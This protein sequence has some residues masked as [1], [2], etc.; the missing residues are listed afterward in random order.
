MK[1][2]DFL[3]KHKGERCFVICNG[4]SLNKHNL[5]LLKN[6][7]TIG[8]NRIYL[9]E[10]FS[11]TYYTIEDSR[12]VQQFHEEINNWTKPQIKFIP[13]DYRTVITGDDVVYIKFRKYKR[14]QLGNYVFKFVEKP[15][16]IFYWGGS[17]TFLS[18]QLAH[19]MGCNPI[20]I[21]GADHYWGEKSKRRGVE[22]STEDDKWHFH[23]DYYGKGKEWNLPVVDR[24]TR[25][26]ECARKAANM[27]GF[28]IYNATIGGYLEV[29]D[30]VDY[31][32]LFRRRNSRHD[33]SWNQSVC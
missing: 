16:P 26:Y 22:I 31:D 30:R 1:I 10:S 23:P 3:D 15:K 5:N 14:G 27:Y 6:E 18:L 13:F 24:I 8:A 29:F 7:I 32:A 4:P 21:I 12:D 28:R 20:Y 2:E 17:V 9:H 11:P 25:S 19:W 33:N